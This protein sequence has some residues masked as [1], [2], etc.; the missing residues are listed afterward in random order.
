MLWYILAAIVVALVWASV[1]ILE[2]PLWIG[3]AVTA[4]V[5]AGLIAWFV[6]RRINQSKSARELE[7]AIHDQADAHA[8]NV[9]PDL[10]P[11]IQQMQAEFA[12]AV[13]SL[14]SSKLARGGR[15]ALSVLPWYMIIGP[16]GSGKSTA[17]RNS[18]LHFP[19][20]S[21]RGGGV[22][23][24]GG[25]RNCEWWL[26]NEAV[27]LD[28]AGR[29][30][31]QDDDREEWLTFLDTLSKH[32][33]KKPVNGLLVAVSIGDL[34]QEDE[35]AAA[36][37][38]Q[39]MRERVDEV[40]SK[41]KMIV[42][43]YVLF[44]K[45][46]L[47]SGFVETFGDLPKSERGQMWGFTLSMSERNRGT[48]ELFNE[49]FFELAEILEKRALF[50][51]GQERK[52]ESRERIYQF[53][54]QFDT[55]RTNLVE[56]TQAL[57][58]ENVYQDTPFLRGVYFT[59]GTQEGRPFD[60]M[61]QNIA[62]ATGIPYSVSDGSESVVDAKSYFLRDVFSKVIFP[63][64]KLAIR[65]SSERQREAIRQYVYAGLC[66][67]AAALMLFFPA[68]SFFKNREWVHST[69]ERVESVRAEV[70]AATL[71]PASLQKLEP[72]RERMDMLYQFREDGPP[73]SMQFGMHPG[74]ELFE[75][76]RGYYGSA[77]QKM[78]I[79]PLLAI[80]AEEMDAFDRKFENTGQIPDDVEHVE[81]YDKLKMYL[82]TTGPRPENEPP[83]DSAEG[84]YQTW[85]A[86]K[87][88]QRWGRKWGSE[89]SP[90]R[91]SSAESHAMTFAKL[92]ATDSS[93]LTARDEVLV[94]RTRA[95][96]AQFPFAALA[97][98]QVLASP[99]LDGYELSLSTLLGGNSPHLKSDARIRGAFT[100]K[101]WVDVVRDSLNADALGE[102]TW[103]V[104]RK[105]EGGDTGLRLRQLRSQ[106]FQRYVDE[107]LAFLDSLKMSQPA[108]NPRA[109]ALLEDLT[110]G[111]SP[112]LRR[113]F[114][115]VAY[116]TQLAPT[117]MEAAASGGIKKITDRLRPKD[118]RGPAG[119]ARAA[120]AG[121]L[122]G[123]SQDELLE[124]SDVAGA[125]TG[126][127]SFG[128]PP[129]P[130]QGEE[131]AKVSVPLDSYQ[132]Q[133]A[134]LRDALRNDMDNPDDHAPLN[135]RVR[136]ARN[137]VR[138]LIDT[139]EIGW[140]PRLESLLWPPIEGVSRTSA[141]GEASGTNSKWCSSVVTAFD[142]SL[143]GRYPFSPNGHDA[144]LAD[145]ADF[146][147]PAQGTVWS[148]YSSTLQSNVLKEGSRY[149][150]TSRLGST[151][152]NAYRSQILTFL[153]RA[154]EISSSLFSPGAQELGTQFYIHIQPSPRV[155]A[156]TFSVD[157]Q[158]YEYRN[159]PEEWHAMKWP[160]AG[161][162]LGAAIRVRTNNGVTEALEQEGEWGLF[163]LLEAG[164]TKAQAGSR[165]FTTTWRIH[166]LDVEVAVDFRPARSETPF[167][168]APRAGQSVRLLGPFRRAGV[169]PPRSI[170][171][172]S[173]PC[174]G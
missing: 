56:Y 76:V 166:A 103:V 21:A 52:L 88:G 108:D 87:V 13:S 18:G 8:K 105:S 142:R 55:L 11:E 66:F 152:G 73:L 146:Y 22:K 77:V 91:V 149:K 54:L 85:L 111:D 84:K 89:A 163:R 80:D 118:A 156:I 65:S 68:I 112:V 162:G 169:Q 126:F 171:K 100:Q 98:E 29:Y 49:R 27:I 172:G 121:A 6:V 132:E 165:V 117:K 7:K 134:F 62:K 116:N 139:Q 97:L 168:G 102:E 129:P 23:G 75:S 37:L 46:D 82:L 53:P 57:F 45:C 5:V 67:G 104:A 94:K 60:A 141:S 61:M 81:Y 130:R 44:T 119:Q 147:R 170:A 33:A 93:L 30:S 173:P 15:D 155:A 64:Q 71:G 122:S 28:T 59:S 158:S 114:R 25:T 99:K 167:F 20:L 31:T 157:G 115:A 26:T 107:W 38:G 133:L 110:R 113:L 106:Y 143:A 63:D 58:A 164:T 140:R 50:R 151:A 144:A 1:I 174:S 123:G 17:L 74:D 120:A 128:V 109:L 14:K 69:R 39:K 79:K 154:S 24:V 153:D 12:K 95:A 101:G 3:I 35:E 124:L 32:R 43:V 19:Y 72:L 16:P 127:I 2:L 4:A 148:F 150:F 40:M 145:V 131:A 138:D 96:L 70:K 92:L 36:A 137:R 41:L 9:R 161:K 160:N 136:E 83:L 90:E 10:Q 48:A 34:A 78:L 51:L 135:N 47:I 125:F 159:G 86:E 42:P